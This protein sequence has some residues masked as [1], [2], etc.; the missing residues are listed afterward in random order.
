MATSQIVIFWKGKGG[1]R[2]DRTEEGKERVVYC[3]PS[4]AKI[5]RNVVV[6]DT[7]FNTGSFCTHPPD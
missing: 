2:K 3:H 5:C 7:I 1:K 6:F 4:G